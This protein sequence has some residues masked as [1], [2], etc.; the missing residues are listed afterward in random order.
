MK[1]FFNNSTIPEPLDPREA[2][3]GGRTNATRLLVQCTDDQYLSYVDVVS[4]Y[5]WG[6]KWTEFPVGHPEILTE[7]FQ[8]ITPQRNPYF[9]IIKCTVLPPKKL[10]HPVL[11][12][13]LNNKL[14][15]PLCL[16]CA[17][18]ENNDDC[19]HTD[20]ERAI[21]GAWVST[22]LNKALEMGYTMIK[23][24]TVSDKRE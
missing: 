17:Q 6:V 13:A 22:E 18:M 15:F 5:P 3:R 12:L 24:H 9:G 23:V 1:G 14:L 7:N 10:Y 19:S 20:S 16:T 11:P 2:L 4:L 21:T 8:P